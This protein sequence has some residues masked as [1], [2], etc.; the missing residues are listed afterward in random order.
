MR[1][2]ILFFL[3]CAVIAA[4]TQDT[5]PTQTS[6]PLKVG[7]DPTYPPFEMRDTS[8]NLTGVSVDLAKAIGKHLSRPIE[9]VPLDFQG[10]L[11]ALQTGKI[12]LVISSMTATAERA[13]KVAFSAPYVENGL[14]LL[15]PLNS[16][17]TSINS[18]D[19]PGRT[20]VVRTGTTGHV[21]AAKNIHS[22]Q[23]IPLELTEACANEVLN[24]NVDAFIYDQLSVLEYAARHPTKLRAIA[25][26]FQKEAWA[27]AMR[28]D[29]PELLAQVNSALNT[30]RRDKFLLESFTKYPVLA[31]RRAQLEAQGQPL[32]FILGEEAKNAAE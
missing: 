19:K 7:L 26:A 29:Q 10:L 11:P 15:V 8:G 20:V 22:A 24:G 27:I 23:V 3:V 32:F 2:R 21:Y 31:E 18:L 25:Q 12:D 13:Q 28:Q 4:C 5:P 6:K 30:L 14:C 1:R 16:D 9:C 17:L